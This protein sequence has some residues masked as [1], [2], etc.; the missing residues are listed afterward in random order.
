MKVDGVLL[1]EYWERCSLTAAGQRATNPANAKRNPRRAKLYKL[2]K[3]AE[4]AVNMATG[5]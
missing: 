2:S 1:I 3:K 4:K 5:P